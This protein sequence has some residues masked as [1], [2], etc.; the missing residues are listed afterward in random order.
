M[1]DT[2]DQFLDWEDPLEEEMAAYP[3]SLAWMKSH[4]QRGAWWA[5]IH[6]VAESEMTGHIHT[7]NSL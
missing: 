7:Y 1:Q 4:G 5:T 3:S 2:W 6:G